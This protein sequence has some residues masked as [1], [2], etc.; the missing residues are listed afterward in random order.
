V[1]EVVVV[2]VVEEVV[3]VVEEVVAV[4]EEGAV[5]EIILPA[6]KM[7]RRMG[8][9]GRGLLGL[10]GFR[11]NSMVVNTIATCRAENQLRNGVL[12]WRTPVFIPGS[13]GGDSPGCR[14][15]SS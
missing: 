10:V 3:A 11:I 1:E 6:V 5:V 7:F 8:A 12:S 15:R 13:S 14:S 9:G 4:V 2:V